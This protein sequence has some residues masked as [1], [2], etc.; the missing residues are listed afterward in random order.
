[1]EYY[2]GG[3]DRA[4]WRYRSRY[5]SVVEYDFS[6]VT[7]EVV[8]NYVPFKWTAEALR[9]IA[10]SGAVGASLGVL[11]AFAVNTI[12]VEVSLSSV[13]SC[14]F[15][16]SVILMGCVIIWRSLASNPY[17]HPDEMKA[18]QATK[19]CLT[20]FAAVNILTGLMC[21]ALD[22]STLLMR[23]AF[24]RLVAFSLLGMSAS[25]AMTFG[26]VDLLNLALGFCRPQ[27]ARPLVESILQIYVVLACSSAMGILFG[28][29][30]GATG[31]AT[32][33]LGLALSLANRSSIRSATKGVITAHVI[34]PYLCYPIGVICGGFTGIS[35]E[36]IR[37]LEARFDKVDMPVEFDAD[38]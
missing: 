30:F 3:I 11:V 29:L 38:I 2:L 18:A 17:A 19:R 20:V 28:A 21:L 31:G 10:V 7:G 12:L 14:Y 33:R 32:P 23:S 6:P 36:Y 5:S 35:S 9:S 8:S 15:G 27:D 34:N 25:F 1:M 26:L 13:F 24:L 22:T 4:L 37:K 16:V